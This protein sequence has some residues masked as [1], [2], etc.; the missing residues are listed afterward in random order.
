MHTHNHEGSAG[1]IVPGGHSG[2]GWN[3]AA[4]AVKIADKFPGSAFLYGAA[5]KE[6]LTRVVERMGLVVPVKSMTDQT[7]IHCTT[8]PK[9]PTQTGYDASIYGASRMAREK[10]WKSQGS[11]MDPISKTELK[12]LVDELK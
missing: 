12:E 6:E 9:P 10:G 11:A 1:S 4:W 7:C 5:Y 3:M 8:G 2:T